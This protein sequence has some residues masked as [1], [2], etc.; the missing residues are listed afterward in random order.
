MV[1]NLALPMTA[2]IRFLAL[3]KPTQRSD[4]G[5]FAITE[6]LFA[7]GDELLEREVHRCEA[8]H[9]VLEVEQLLCCQRSCRFAVSRPAVG[10]ESLW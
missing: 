4:Q 1:T 3:G 7:G 8:R 9:S 5:A 2:Q 6:W 10:G